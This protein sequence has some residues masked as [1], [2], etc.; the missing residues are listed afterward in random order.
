MNLIIIV[1]LNSIL[2]VTIGATATWWLWKS[3]YLQKVREKDGVVSNHIEEAINNL[4]GLVVRVAFDVDEHSNQVGAINDSLNSNENHK[5]STLVDV[6]SRLLHMN[7][8]M[9]EKLASTEGQLREQTKQIQVNASKARTDALTLLANRRAYDEELVRHIAE[10]RRHHR[11]F[12]VIIADVDHF[13]KINDTYGHPIGDEVLRNVARVLRGTARDM[14]FVARFGGEEFSIILPGTN[15]NDASRAAMRACSA[16]G[17]SKLRHNEKEYQVSISLGVAEIQEHEDG[18]MLIARADEALYTAK[19]NGRNCVCRHDGKEIDEISLLDKGIAEANPEKQSAMKISEAPKVLVNDHSV[20]RRFKEAKPECQDTVEHDVGLDVCNRT[21]FC[22]R[23]RNKIAELDQ[24]HLPSSVLFI[25][26]QC[27]QDD[28]TSCACEVCDAVTLALVRSISEVD[29][30]TEIVSHYAPGCIAIVIPVTDHDD[31][32]RVTEHLQQ[33]WPKY[34][35]SELV[36]HACVALNIGVTSLRK[37]D[38]IL[39]LLKRVEDALDASINEGCNLT[40]Y[41]DGTSCMPIVA[42]LETMESTA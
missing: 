13:K 1:L 20:S 31:L 39:A 17:N 5:S 15:L 18:I 4:H 32:L 9:Q 7:Q 41:H 37:Q 34:T 25:K 42:M 3:R 14:D 33:E 11:I 12:S 29:I 21:T 35:M 19:N 6:V 27:R 30:D 10:Y 38:D 8:Q 2:M 22:Q 40:Y 24:G 16:V 36:E 28:A 26:A 23:I